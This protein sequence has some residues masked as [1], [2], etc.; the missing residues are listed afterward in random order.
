M[1]HSGCYTVYSA[2]SKERGI[3]GGIVVIDKNL[4]IEGN[5]FSQC[6]LEE[7]LKLLGAADQSESKDLPEDEGTTVDTKEEK[8]GQKD[9]I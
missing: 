2:P 7:A 5:V 6:S 8:L 9:K 1:S 3:L 4:E